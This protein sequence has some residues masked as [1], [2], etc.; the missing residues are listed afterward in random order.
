MITLTPSTVI[1]DITRAVKG[2][3]TESGPNAVSST[4]ATFDF[5]GESS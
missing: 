5:L 2:S 1:Y 3:A 4:K